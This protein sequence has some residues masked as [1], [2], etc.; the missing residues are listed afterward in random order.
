VSVASKLLASG[1][2]KPTG[3]EVFTSSGTWTA[4]AHV[5]SVSVVCIGAGGQGGVNFGTPPDPTR[6]GGGGGLG[7][8]NNISVTPNQSY[9]VVINSTGS[10]FISQGTVFGGK[11]DNGGFNYNPAAQGGGYA[12]DGGGAGGDGG[13]YPNGS[14]LGGGGGDAGNYNSDGDDGGYDTGLNGDGSGISGNDTGSY[15]YG[16]A[17]GQN[18]GAGVVQIRWGV[19]KDY[20]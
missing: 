12:G 7:W 3:S 2:P 17:G 1:T 4:P 10:W 11:G 20:S 8:K 6:G 15:G 9:D 16:G 19:G 18:G 14:D 5:Y 13:S